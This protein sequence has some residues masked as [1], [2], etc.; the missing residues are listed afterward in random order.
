MKVRLKS[1]K[2]LLFLPFIIFLGGLLPGFFVTQNKTD[3]SAAS[4]RDFNPGRII[5][6]AVF[7]NKNTMSVQDIQNFL[8]R[9]I[10]NCDTWGTGRATEFGSSLTR[11]QYAASRGW[12]APPYSCLNNYHENPTTGENSYTKGGGAFA[13][14]ISA[15]QIIYDAAQQY[16]INPQVLLVLLKKESAGPLTSDNW[17][18][19]SQYAYAMGYAC[20]DSGPGFS[21]NCSSEKAGFYKQMSL[22]AWQLKYYKDHPNDYRYKIGWNNIQY[23]PD[24]ACGTK[25]VYIEN[26]ATLSLYIYTPYTPNDAALA[27]YPGTA[28]CGAYGNRN[29]FMFFSE[30]F[31]GTQSLAIQPKIEDRYYALGGLTSYLG[32]PTTLG[33]CGIPGDGCYQNF[34]YGHIYWS[35]ATGAWDVSGAI[36]D[37]WIQKGAERSIHGYPTGAEARGLKDGGAYQAYQVG[38]IYWSAATGAWDVSGAIGDRWIALGAEKSL[39]GYPKE[40]ET[41]GLKGGGSY[42]QF[43]IGRVYWSPTTGAHPISGGIGDYWLSRGAQNSTL[44]Y[45]TSG[46]KTDT[47]GRVYQEFEGGKIYWTAAR[48]AW[49]VLANIDERYGALD[50]INGYL[51][52]PYTLGGCGIKSDG[53]YQNFLGGNIYWSAATGAWDVSGGI[54]AR[55]IALGAERSLIGYP[56]S[57]EVRGLKNSGAYQN[58]ENGRIYWSAAT[59]AWDVSGAIKDRWAIFGSENSLF[60]YP[61]G[62]EIRGLRDGGSYQQFQIGRIY[63]SAATGAHPVAGGIGDYWRQKG[64]E[65]STLG[66]PT[67]GEQIDSQGRVYQQ[68]ESG[69]VYWTAAR[70]AWN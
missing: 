18:L 37:R 47:S 64:A 50:G 45:P 40:S 29:F 34:Q 44:G 23:S 11:A 31:G 14:G 51:G 67:S 3:A 13:G 12:H 19:K 35:A 70:G 57:A 48:G 38:R 39:F 10:P 36:G 9:T 25:R 60:G 42:Q 41:Y 62:P 49:G 6:D 59:G 58:Y 17:P 7:Y 24:P 30:W 56:A 15:A 52:T 5:D 20:P 8:N 54:G 16:G 61:N 63:W 53:C 32:K 68:F 46:E 55:W 22:A 2:I 66:Y 21:A 27:S 4:V 65:K 69:T 33:A 26:M 43:Q 1:N 28:H